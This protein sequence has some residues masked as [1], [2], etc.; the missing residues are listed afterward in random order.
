MIKVISSL[1]ILAGVVL[2]S[3]CKPDTYQSYTLYSQSMPGGVLVPA[4]RPVELATSGDASQV[5]LAASQKPKARIS[6]ID[7]G[8]AASR[9]QDLSVIVDVSEQTMKVRLDGELAYQWPVSTARNGMHTPRGD[10]GVQWLSEFHKSSLY[11]NA[12]MPYSIFF[13]GNFAI[14]GTTDVVSIGTPASAGC[15][16]LIP[17]DAAVLFAAVKTVGTDNVSIKIKD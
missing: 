3:G 17:D 4:Q 11:N 15:V 12:P 14:H 9:G 8:I 2:L 13:N 10:Y 7:S 5:A 6:R 16:R 1:V